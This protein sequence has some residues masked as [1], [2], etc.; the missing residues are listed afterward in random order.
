MM[1]T[2]S[3]QS[4]SRVDDRHRGSQPNPHHIVG[5]DP[6]RRVTGLRI[7]MTGEVVL[8]R[9]QFLSDSID[10]RGEVRDAHEFDGAVLQNAARLLDS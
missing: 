2:R 6:H 5:R 9:R 3:A 4:S 7:D 1:A 8:T 10:Q